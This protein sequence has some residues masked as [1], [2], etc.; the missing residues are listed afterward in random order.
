MNAPT[1][2]PRVLVV[3]DN[4]MLRALLE[5]ILLAEGF[6]VSVADSVDQALGLGAAGFDVILVDLRLGDRPGTDLIAELC[7]DDPAARRRFAILTGAAGVDPVPA[8]IPVVAKPFT[9]DSLLSAIHEVL[10]AAPG[11]DAR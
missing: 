9:A 11:P 3:D 2:G 5:R 10:R 6:Q 4:E 8:G 7:R 1:G